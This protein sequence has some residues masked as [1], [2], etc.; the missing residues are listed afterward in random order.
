[1]Y[2]QDVGHGSC[3]DVGHGSCGGASGGI[4]NHRTD[5]D[6]AFEMGLENWIGNV[7]APPVAPKCLFKEWINEREWEFV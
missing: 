1:M 2:C 5:A 4:L 6:M 7:P 3:Q